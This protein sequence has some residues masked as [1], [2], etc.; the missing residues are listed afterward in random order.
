MNWVPSIVLLLVKLGV[1]LAGLLLGAAWLAFAERKL[2]GRMQIRLGPNRAG[3]HGLL[4][5]LADIVKM[6]T[7]EDTMPQGADRVVFRYAPAITAVTALLIFAVVPF[8]RDL[9]I[10]GRRLPLVVADLNVGLLFVIALSSLSVYGVFLGAWASNSKYSLMGGIRAAAQTISCELAMGLSLVPVVML[11]RSFSLVDIVQ[12]QRHIP[13]ALAQPLAF[14]IFFVSSLAEIKRIP[15][16]LPEAENELVAGY[17]TEYSG[18]RFGLYFMGEYTAMI[19]LGSLTAVFFLGGWRG[20]W[21][22]SLVWFFIKV[23]LVVFALI[24]SR[25]TL[26]RLRYDQLMSLGWKLM[27]P[28]ALLNI[29]VTGGVL[30]LWGV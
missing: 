16:D 11:A 29:V 26:P 12:A 2:L 21:L 3:P 24:W 5:P 18:M 7:K 14:V 17:H 1:I 15:F 9:N 23:F 13:F 10:A 28:L 6:L 27:I 25:A 30:V 8:G 4:Q 19:V 22:P 20:P